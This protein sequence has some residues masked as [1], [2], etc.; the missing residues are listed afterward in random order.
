MSSFSID[1]HKSFMGW[2]KHAA[3]NSK[4]IRRQV[5]A[6]IVGN[7]G[8]YT[9]VHNGPSCRSTHALQE[10]CLRNKLNIPSG[11]R[12]EICRGLH[13]EQ[14]AIAQAARNGFSTDDAIM[15]C[16]LHPCSVCAKMIIA[17]GITRVYYLEDYTDMLAA[18][19]FEEAGISTTKLQDFREI[20]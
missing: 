18:K 9:Q 13:A 2:A 7:Q 6:V 14:D 20:R 3:S 17:A 1:E 11:T 15:Y 19:L 4:C 10:G 5:G 8:V 16:T 12:Q